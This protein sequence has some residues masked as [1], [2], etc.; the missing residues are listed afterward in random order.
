MGI[1]VSGGWLLTPLRRLPALFREDGA[2]LPALTGI[3]AWAAFWVLLY[4][5]WVFSVPR[6]IAIPLGGFSL[7]LTPL[8]SLG[9]AGVSIFF[10]LSGFLLGVP[11]AEWQLGLRRRPDLGRYLFRRVARVFPAYYAQL[12][13]LLV[14]AVFVPGQKTLSDWPSLVRHLFML[15][16]P[17]PVGVTPLNLVW[18][19]LPIE[20]SFYLVLP[21]L[22]F[23]LRPG[24]WGWLLLASFAAMSAWRFMTVSWLSEAPIQQR[25]YTS[26]QLPGSFDMFGLGMLAALLY[27]NRDR[28]P[29]WLIPKRDPSR[30]ALLGLV[31]VVAAVYWLFAERHHYWANYPIFY[32]WTP[33]LSLGTAAAVLAGAIGSRLT[34]ALFG[35]R[36]MVF[37]GLVSYSVYLWH[38]VLMGW[39]NA[40]PLLQGLQGYRL[41]WLLLLSVPVI[42]A[43]AAVSYLLVERPFMRMR[44]R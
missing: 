23:L 28:L 42:Y 12:A 44:R 33:A 25:V 19:T 14:V 11:F 6:T 16:N 7:D 9:G 2:H 34:D 3:R 24:R 18:W 36:V 17:P 1:P 40:T 13:I 37:A 35:N 26:Y 27:V 5:A 43:V 20:F 41:P 15:F 8:V 10:V 21:L 22:A 4:H 30:L 39:L 31:L 29:D 32:L 38:I